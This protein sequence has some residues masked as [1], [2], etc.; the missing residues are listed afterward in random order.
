MFGPLH[1]RTLVYVAAGLPP[2]AVA[3]LWLLFVPPLWLYVDSTTFLLFPMAQVPQFPPLY[4]IIVHAFESHFGLNPKMLHALLFVQHAL[5]AGSII[6]L[7]SAYDR[8][9]HAFIMS[10]AAVAGS[11][12]GSFAHSVST[13]AVDLPFLALLCGVAVRYCLRG[14][15][16][17]LLPMFFVSVL[18]LALTRHASPIFAFIVPLYFIFLAL[19][20]I[21]FRS[22]S[23]KAGQC[24]HMLSVHCARLGDQLTADTRNMSHVGQRL[25]LL[26]NRAPG[27]PSCPR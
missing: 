8:P 27:M 6:Y 10:T 21:C 1:A 14:W 23:R 22:P 26:D 4:P 16:L 25:L 3:T 19:I 11:W 17:E 12:M 7:G 24:D 9:L 18:G 20:A 5:L 15:R 2:L 13:Q